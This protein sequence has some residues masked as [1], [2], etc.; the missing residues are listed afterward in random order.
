MIAVSGAEDPFGTADIRARVI[1]AWAAAP[2]RFRED[3]NAEEDLVRGGYRD[4][5]VVE[6]AQNA[7]DAATRAGVRGR[8][9][10]R[11]DENALV[12]SNTGA[13][14]DAAGVESLSTLRASAKRGLPAAEAT[15]GRFGVGFAA[16]LAVTD[17][18]S[19]AS[20]TGAVRWSSTEARLAV[21]GVPTLRDELDQRTGHVPVLRLPMVSEGTPDPG[22]DTTIRLPLRDVIARE[23]VR[24]LLS[25]VDD[26]LLLSLPALEEIVVEADGARRVV[27]DAARWHVVRRTGPLEPRLLID[28]PTEERAVRSWSV[29][30]AR[31]LAGQPVPGTVHAPTATD[32]PLELPALLIAS[33]PLDPSRRHVAPGPLTDFLVMQAARAYADLAGEVADPLSLVPAT[34]IVG[35]LDAALRRAIIEAMAE[36][37]LLKSPQGRVRPRDATSVVDASEPVREILS[38]VLPGLVADHR[39]LDRLGSRRMA[40]VDVVDLLA[41]LDRSPS[42]WHALY[43]ALE[44]ILPATGTEQ[45]GAL[46]VPLSD[47]R[48]VRGARG[49]LIP[50]EPLPHG[51]DRLGLRIVHRQAVHPLL[52]RLGALNASA[53]TVLADPAVRAA[54][55]CAADSPEPVDVSEVV[56]SLVEHA[57]VQPG[58]LAWLADLL[59]PDA[60]GDLTPA[61]DLVLPGSL[62]AQV[63]DPEELDAPHESV[64][65]RWSPAVLA[66]AGVLSTFRVVRDEDV[67]VEEAADHDLAD[68]QEWVEHVLAG[69]PPHDLPPLLPELVAISD[70]DLVRPD[71]WPRVLTELATTA[72]LRSAVVDPA[73]MLLA[74]GR[75]ATAPSYSAWWLRE[76]ALIDGRRPT[77]YALPSATDLTGLYDVFRAERA[78]GGPDDAF[79]A[80]IGVRTSLAALLDERDGPDDLLRRVVAEHAHVA[81]DQ[82]SRLYVAVSGLDPGRVTPPEQLVVP[83]GR[84]VPA[85]DALVLDEPQHLQLTWPVP[86]ILVPLSA[87]ADLAE[88][89]DLRTTGSVRS[90][91]VAPAGG[92]VQL[93]PD[94]LRSWMPELPAHWCEHDALLVD[95]DEVDWW[96]D[97]DDV[98]HAC[99]VDG[100]ARAL[101]WAAARWDARH[102]IAAILADPGR[103]AE[104]VAEAAL[105]G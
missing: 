11:L 13:P 39:A 99:T 71:A 45:L 104:L 31:P 63:S 42:W 41:D 43:D 48:T 50:A 10:L 17:E 91:G 40:V 83:G 24:Q 38:D 32:E 59:L 3:A 5:V 75:S 49:L 19:I 73:R 76:H 20:A 26:A 69:A 44:Q 54:I 92:R 29:A 103:Q 37:P 68:E 87:A 1:A 30:W 36:A 81:D 60:Q 21:D 58:E 67:P 7:A 9:L 6:L 23:T 101:A 15:V 51:L 55:D 34:S 14:L 66:A 88:V 82:L 80:A 89:L 57:D 97:P 16:V 94:S 93:V 77:A 22:F 65:Q 96:V 33:F 78:A 72:E 27:S 18:P 8:L 52:L 102:V 25:D 53:R 2:S 85:R 100:L 79:L 46:P 47:G 62:L 4:R 61:G 12:V 84:I 64:L 70:L 28:R 74:D 35:A 95:G 90:G 86:P 56:L 105:E 98:P